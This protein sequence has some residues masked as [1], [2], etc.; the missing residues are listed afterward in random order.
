MHRF[1]KRTISV[2]F[3]VVISLL[4]AGV[5][6]AF[7]TGGGAGTGT[8]TTGTSTAITVNQTSTITGL[9]PGSP[10]QTLSGTF[11][12]NNTAPVFVTSVS[13]T[14][15]GT[16]DPGCTATDYTIAGSAPVN[17]QVPVGTGGSW[18]GLTIAFNN[19]VGT[20]QDACKNATVNIAYTSN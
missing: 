6:F 15:T 1:G 14:V 18:T 10:A 2:A 3:G 5:A 7:W 8:A 13:A 19:K 12:N 11:T 20:N 16:S 4:G 17:A 9:A